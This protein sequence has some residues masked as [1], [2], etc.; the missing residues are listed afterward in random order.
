MRTRLAQAALGL[1]AMTATISPRPASAY[2]IA[3]VRG[4]FYYDSTGRVVGHRTAE[5]PD[6]LERIPMSHREKFERMGLAIP[7]R[8]ARL[9]RRP[10]FPKPA[11]VDAHEGLSHERVIVKFIEGTQV[12]LRSG[13]LQADGVTLP[14]VDAVLARFPDATLQRCFGAEERILDE[15]KDTGERISGRELADLNNFYVL[16]FDAPSRRGVDLANELLALDIVETAYLQAKAAP[17]ACPADAFPATPNWVASQNYL[18]AAPAGLNSQYAWSYHAGG[19]GFGPSYWIADCEWDWCTNHED[20]DFDASDVLNGLSGIADPDHG[21]AVLGEI[22]ACANAHG[23]TGMTPDVTLKAC[24]FDSEVSWAANI[25]EAD[26]WLVSGE[27][28][29]LEIHI[30]GPV[31]GLACNPGCLLC[32][33]NSQSQWEFVPVEWDAACFAAIQTATANGIIVV[34]AA[35]NGGM[36][37]DS[38]VYGGW[39]NPIHDSGA[40]MVGAG[41]AGSHSPI[42]W[43]N[44]GSRVNVH[45]YG[46]AVYTTGYGGL[47][48][49]NGFCDQQYTSSFGGTSSASPMIVG[50]CASL[51]GIS[52]AKYGV[53]LTPAQMRVSVAIGGTPQG[54]PLSRNIG[55]MPDLV[56][57]IN[58]I[59][60]D[61]VASYTPAGWTYPAVPRSLGDTNGGYAPLQVGALPGEVAG[62]YWNWTEENP[63]YSYT[64]TVNNPQAGLFLDESFERICL[65]SN[66]APGAWQWCGNDGPYFVKGGRH[67]LLARA[68]WADVEAEWSETNNDWSRQYIWSPAVLALNA[69]VIRSYDPPRTSTGSGPYYNAEGFSGATGGFY[70]HAFAVLPADASTDHDIYLHTEVPLNVP[71]QGFG[72]TVAQSGGA[73]AVSDFVI[74]DRNTVAGGTYWASGINWSGTGNKLVEFDQDQGIVANPGVNGPYTLGAGEVV[75]LHEIFLAGGVATRIQIQWVSGNADYGVSVHNDPSGFTNK[76]AAIPGGFSDSWGPTADEFVVV[77]PSVGAWHGICVWKR[78]WAG[79]NEAVT[80]NLVVSQIP[81]LTDATPIGWYG[82]VVPRNTTDAGLFFAPLPATLTGNQTTTSFN[83]STINQGPGSVAS[84]WQTEL[85]VDDVDHWTGFAPASTGQGLFAQW[86]NTLQG[87]DP[88]SLVRGGR[89]HVRV[90]SDALG[91]V[92]ELPET[93]NSFVDWFVW[94][95]LD[96]ANQVAVGRAA[97][98]RMHPLGWGPYPSSDGVRSAFPTT[99]WTAVGVLPEGGGADYDVFLHT[100]SVGSKDGF[101]PQ[102]TWSQDLNGASDFC[103]VNHNVVPFGPFDYGVINFNAATDSFTVQQAD[104][105]ILGTVTPGVSRFGAFRLDEGDVLDL[106]EVYVPAPMTVDVSVNN[107][108]GGTNVA[109]IVYDGTIA[110]HS[111]ATGMAYANAAGDGG[112]EHLSVFLNA[113]WYALAVYKSSWTDA[114]KYARYEI[115]FSTNG[116]VVDASQVDPLPTEF[117]LSSARPNPFH[118]QTVIDLAVPANSGRASVAVYDLQGRRIAVLADGQ[119]RPGRHALRWDGRDGD[120]RAV[121]AGVYFVRL[122]TDAGQVTRKIALLR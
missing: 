75:D 49:P 87:L 115:V 36:D 35:G 122:E 77:N 21:T 82:P 55:P 69:P 61:V 63:G 62:T 120:G 114:P 83:F 113:G 57:A 71:Q 109:S 121:A 23:V 97:P 66:L 89:H 51:Q 22:G 6:G 46:S 73:G 103:I 43:S 64:P 26:L 90:D 17:P 60:P 112:D 18:T 96:L 3:E 70:W 76:W 20:L 50:A 39:F 104:G 4:D 37:L 56:E 78:D 53:T 44:A 108:E 52:K 34:E 30:P 47:F 32:P 10:T 45:G 8:T 16:T 118:A 94:T 86:T 58:W 99:Y 117:A 24:D 81:N 28:M 102:L 11:T 98:P 107:L 65:N 7:E 93:D 59:E 100:P 85:A 41:F 42:C 15:N 95:P 80:Y 14:E 88:A 79:W 29:L 84:P 119:E 67:T 68:D 40:I 2:E 48:N 54:A 72:A 1:V 5:L 38:G 106:W 110:Y 25:Q 12:R 116:S 9:E 92:A 111:K 27:I 101:G 105:P 13:R 91:Q 74:V 33:P 19:D 31:S